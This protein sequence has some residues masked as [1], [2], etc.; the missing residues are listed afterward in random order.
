MNALNRIARRLFHQMFVCLL[1]VGNS[2]KCLD[3]DAAVSAQPHK[4]VRPFAGRSKRRPCVP[5]LAEL[6]DRTAWQVD[7]RRAGTG[8]W[9]PNPELVAARMHRRLPARRVSAFK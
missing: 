9:E 7:E 2:S 6:A 4:R 5:A 8:K 3:L 1:Y